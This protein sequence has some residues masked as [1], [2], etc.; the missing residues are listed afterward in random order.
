MS[1]ERKVPGG[2][3]SRLARLAGTGVRTGVG[4]LRGDSLSPARQAAEVLG[5]MRGVA[6][7]VGQMASYVDGVIPEQHKEAYE[8]AMKTLRSQA[9]RSS[10]EDI[11]RQVEE[12]LGGPLDRHF[13]RWDDA[14]IAS[15]SIGQVHRAALEDGTEVA[16]KVQHPGIVKAVE[17]DLAN[18]GLVEGIVGALGFGKYDVKGMM[19][20]VRQRFRE[21]LD[22][23]LEADRLEQFAAIHA[24]DSTVLIPGVYRS[25]SSTRVLT[26]EFVGGIGF[27]EACAAGEEE[28][29]LWAETL[30]RFV[31]R[32]N[33]V[34][35]RFNADPH[36]G[37]YIF[38]E[39][40]RIGFLD[41]GCVQ[42]IP[43]QRLNDAR[44]MHRAALVGDEA[45][46][47]RAVTTIL[48]SRPGRIEDMAV[49]Y[50]RRTFDP[51]TKAP[52]RMTREYAGSLL[53]EMKQMALAARKAPPDEFFTM[54]ADNLF[55]NRM[56]FGFYSVLARLDAEVDYA[57]VEHDFWHEVPGFELSR[58]A[59]G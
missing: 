26:T 6:A 34:A 47:T 1:D 22:Y 18:A 51:V 48:N 49:A 5:S 4:L 19:A 41:F 44:E 14:P 25:H 42:E 54:E 58:T 36:P 45:A 33:L 15:A 56:Q 12:E 30:W 52:F 57:R 2:R 24:H 3:L 16:V 11:R 9:P 40:G 29:R 7:K 28:R 20:V 46:F 10:P 39:D 31:C 17:S 55:M 27:D 53:A 59:S 37:N 23:G 35:G 38:Q 32:G 43:P 8:S 50:M 21:E 13:A